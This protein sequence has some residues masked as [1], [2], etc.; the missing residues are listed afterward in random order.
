MYPLTHA[1]ENVPSM[2]PNH[3]IKIQPDLDFGFVGGRQSTRRSHNLQNDMEP[4]QLFLVPRGDR[5]GEAAPSAHLQLLRYIA[6]TLRRGDQANK[7]ARQ[8][9]NQ[10]HAPQPSP[11]RCND[12]TLS[13]HI[14]PE[15]S[16]NN[17]FFRRVVHLGWGNR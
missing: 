1:T 2:L 13:G 8:R 3:V 9:R 10:Q 7:L 14:L 4:A 6:Q 15:R 11:L 17:K 5:F 16:S 12:S